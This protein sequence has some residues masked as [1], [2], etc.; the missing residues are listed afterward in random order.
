MRTKINSRPARLIAS[1]GCR[2]KQLKALSC[3]DCPLRQCAV[4]LKRLMGVQVG[5]LVP[6]PRP[7]GQLCT[8]QVGDEL[9]II[10]FGLVSSQTHTQPCL[11]S[12]VE[13]MNAVV[14][15][16]LYVCVGCTNMQVA[17]CAG[18]GC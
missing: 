8:G 10:F 9:M 18:N 12:A 3:Q 1:C 5:V 13:T 15:C 7:T 2:H 16:C 6:E 17:L 11:K 14:I 4:L